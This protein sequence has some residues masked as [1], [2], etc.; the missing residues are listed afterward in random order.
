MIAFNPANHYFVADDGR[1][2]CTATMA[3]VAA[4]D[5]AYVAWLAIGNTALRWPGADAASQTETSVRKVLGAYAYP[6]P[7]ISKRQFYQ[8]L[9]VAGIITQDEA[10][11][12]LATGALPPALAVIVGK[13]AADQQFPAKMA[14][15]GGGDFD[16][17]HPLTIA[18]GA[19]R[20]MTPAQIDAFFNAAAAL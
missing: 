11:A 3:V 16:R 5:A 7:P 13:M 10:L 4:T 19:A 12:V 9:A 20:G 17:N 18:I 1:V 15:I 6:C 8:Q 2:F 14:L